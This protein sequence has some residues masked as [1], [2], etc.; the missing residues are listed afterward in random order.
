M[1]NEIENIIM[2]KK[3]FELTAEE[4]DLI[5]E[6]AETEVDFEQLKFVFKQ[7][8]GIKSAEKPHVDKVVK[9]NLDVLFDKTYSQKRLVW[10]NKLWLFLWPEE[11]RFYVRP[12]L[13]FATVI[14]LI[15]SVVTF[16][17]FNEKSQLAMNESP[18][19]S[20]EK[21]IVNQELKGHLLQGDQEEEVEQGIE[22]SIDSKE[23]ELYQNEKGGG[24]ELEDK[25]LE[26][27]EDFFV[28]DQLTTPAAGA[29]DID[30]LETT[31]ALDEQVESEA[32]YTIGANDG[33]SLTRSVTSAQTKALSPKDKPE[34]FDILTALY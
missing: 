6:F 10:Y 23:L 30:K 18:T 11:A 16:V 33:V 7:V 31:I 34:V 2:N 13:Q 15:V 14:A 17:P 24:W 8:E 19:E 20:R 32:E 22:K 3:Y 4:K 27:T 28:S 12:L 25:K 5:Q 26:V 21:V 1:T 9:A 29:F